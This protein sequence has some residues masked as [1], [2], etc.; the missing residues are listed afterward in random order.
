MVAKKICAGLGD[1]THNTV[2][3][4]H[5]LTPAETTTSERIG[6][7]P[8]CPGPPLYC[9]TAKGKCAPFAHIVLAC[10]VPSGTFRCLLS[11]GRDLSASK[12]PNKTTFATTI[13]NL[14]QPIARRSTYPLSFAHRLG[15]CVGRYL[16]FHCASLPPM[17]PPL[18]FQ[19]SAANDALA[20]SNYW[21]ARLCF[22]STSMSRQTLNLSFRR[23][24][25]S[26]TAFVVAQ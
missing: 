20:D 19:A 6:E 2:S 16:I 7:L 22:G 5:A 26:R 1:S 9:R 18:P 8:H 23:H 17:G 13:D 11:F 3:G 14:R 25:L 10:F 24:F 12:S 4:T 21:P 15:Q